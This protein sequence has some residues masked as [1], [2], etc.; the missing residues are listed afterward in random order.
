MAHVLQAATVI[1][2]L[3]WRAGIVVGFVCLSVCLYA[4]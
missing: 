1:E 2:H 4:Q 3:C